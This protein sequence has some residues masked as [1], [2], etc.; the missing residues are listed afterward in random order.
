MHL[1]IEPN[2]LVKLALL[3]RTRSVSAAAE[4]LGVSQPSMSRALARLRDELKDPLLVRSANAM[5]RTPRGEE[6]LTRLEAWM[7]QT[8]DVVHQQAFDPR[9]LDRQFLVG[10]T[11]FGV[12]TVL[13]PALAR[14]RKEAP[15][16]TVQIVPLDWAAHTALAE[17]RVDMVVSGLDTDPAQLHRK[18]L[19]SDRFACM[20]KHDHPLANDTTDALSLDEYLFYPHIGITVTDTFFDRINQ[21]LGN[22][23]GRRRT[24]V[25]AP[26]FALGPEL[27]DGETLLTL[28]EKAAAHYGAIHSAHYRLAP[29]TLGSL[30]YWLLWHE[31]SHRDPASG[32]LRT[33]LAEACADG[34]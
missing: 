26:Y 13:R 33:K 11:D 6:L 17:G 27:L 21:L 8:A 25:V 29:E 4:A 2:L 5:V 12:L 24:S 15:G 7:T 23:A 3:L 10:S 32:W 31:R 9:T 22:D 19:F 14:I 1:P 18:L 28:P 16:V 34:A 30:D 20:M